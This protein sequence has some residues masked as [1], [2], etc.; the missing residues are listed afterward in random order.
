MKHLCIFHAGRRP[1]PSLTHSS[2]NEE[3]DEGEH[4]GPQAKQEHTMSLAHTDPQPTLLERPRTDEHF[5]ARVSKP[6]V[7][8]LHILQQG[9]DLRS[10]W[11]SAMV[12]MFVFCF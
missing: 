1:L 12:L 4:R 8:L 5:P 2:E 9:W 11:M 7:D 3:A 6:K 10:D